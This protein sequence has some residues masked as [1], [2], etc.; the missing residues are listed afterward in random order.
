MI[1]P[2]EPTEGEQPY[3]VDVGCSSCGEAA[4]V[5]FLAGEPLEE[6]A[7]ICHCGEELTEV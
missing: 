4:I 2:G 1:V 3:D 7:L 5:R 6:S